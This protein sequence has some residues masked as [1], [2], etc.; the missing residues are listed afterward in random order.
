MVA[1]VAFLVGYVICGA[2]SAYKDRKYIACAIDEIITDG[3]VQPLSRTW[4]W[5]VLVYMFEI[6]LWPYFRFKILD[7]SV[8]NGKRNKGSV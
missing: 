5:Y 6:A 8:I 3:A 2:I 4:Y 1:A 7:R